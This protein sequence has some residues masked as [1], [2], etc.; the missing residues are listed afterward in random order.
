MGVSWKHI[1][2]GQRYFHSYTRRALKKALTCTYA[3]PDIPSY[4]PRLTSPRGRHLFFSDPRNR[5]AQP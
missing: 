4:P 1:T 2:A 5:R 3:T